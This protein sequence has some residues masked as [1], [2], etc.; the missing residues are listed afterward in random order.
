MSS[1]KKKNTQNKQTRKK[2]QGGKPL[3]KTYPESQKK[4]YTS[5]NNPRLLIR[6][7]AARR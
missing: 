7:Y 5:Q 6:N 1:K 2:K 4:K 3:G